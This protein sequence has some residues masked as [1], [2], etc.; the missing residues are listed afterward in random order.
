MKLSVI[1]LNYNVK[2]FLRQ[3]IQSVINATQ[4]IKAEIIV[5]DNA[6]NDDSCKM[7]KEF[8]PEVTLIDNK[9]NLGFP[10]GNNQG[11]AV[12]KGEY[13]CVLNPD[14]VVSE[15][16]FDKML[17]FAD[18]QNELGIIGVKLVDG[19]GNF[20]PE[21]KR[22]V[23]T[24]WVA[25]TK[26]SGLYKL[27][28]KMCGK[29]YAMHLNESE[30]GEVDILVGAF[31]L[32]K[33][34]V[35]NKVGG[36][37]EGCF[38]YSDDIDISYSI[39]KLGLRNFYNPQVSVIHYKGE[40]TSKDESFLDRFRQAMNFF[41]KKHFKTNILFDIALKLGI[42]FFSLIKLLKLQK[43]E[44]KAYNPEYYYLIDGDT[45]LKEKLQNHLK[46]EVTHRT[47]DSILSGNKT[48]FNIEIIFNGN[49]IKNETIIESMQNIKGMGFTFKIL[50][51]KSNFIIGA[52][53][54]D[55]R[56]ESIIF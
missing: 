11:V 56:G 5:I 27:F 52:N 16:T 50:P 36:F 23:P 42:K 10:K 8:F 2:Y 29:Y 39:K 20:L 54:S 12:A 17:P 40:S 48:K 46:K 22:G 47:L 24:P 21:S 3:C 4:N 19:T 30:T 14:T 33:R 28:P 6:S 9:E 43:S 26:F 7:V 1:I 13:V 38:M 15:N 34:D 51:K 18:A 44:E 55:S 35:Y 45:K 41:Y 37:D 31:M 32:M 25:F 49:K 53:H